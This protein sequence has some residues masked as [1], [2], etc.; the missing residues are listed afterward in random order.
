MRG[1]KTKENMMRKAPEERNN[2]PKST[3][4]H[5]KKILKEV[6]FCVIVIALG[7][8]VGYY[9]KEIK[10]LLT[11][12]YADSDTVVTD[13]IAANIS[14]VDSAVDGTAL[15][16]EDNKECIDESGALLSLRECEDGKGGNDDN[17]V[18]YFNMYA[19][20][21]VTDNN[22]V[23]FDRNFSNFKGTYPIM[24]KFEQDDCWYAEICCYHFINYET[25]LKKKERFTE[26]KMIILGNAVFVIL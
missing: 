14:L 4:K 17:A 12:E 24:L 1:Y 7:Y 23:C 10:K 16:S 2:T 19:D 3:E 6:M 5:S 8:C 26:E 15:I 18:G 25:K 21:Y 20:K 22:D 11:Y 13:T 9:Y